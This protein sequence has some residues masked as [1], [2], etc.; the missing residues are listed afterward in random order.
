MTE[1]EIQ[2]LRFEKNLSFD[3]NDPFYYYTYD[4]VKF[5]FSLISCTN[6]DIETHDDWYIDV[7]N[8]EPHIR[9]Y[10]FEEVQSL[11]NLITKRIVK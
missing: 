7:F 3:D 10:K 2:L 11:I 6:A 9:F 1:Q 4:I 8:T 5:G